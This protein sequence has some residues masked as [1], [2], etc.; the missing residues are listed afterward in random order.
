MLIFFMLA[1]IK[2][3]LFYSSTSSSFFFDFLSLVC[4]VKI[5]KTSR[6]QKKHIPLYYAGAAGEDAT[7]WRYFRKCYSKGFGT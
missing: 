3:L 6:K 4:L 7:V 5:E 2:K 1:I